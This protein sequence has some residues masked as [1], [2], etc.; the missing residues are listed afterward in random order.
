MMS[1][2][3]ELEAK[4]YPPRLVANGIERARASA[5]IKSAPISP[6]IRGQAFYDLLQAE[7]LGVEAWMAGQQ[8]FIDGQDSSNL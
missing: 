6:T 5:E 3:L 4:G 1:S 2:Q 7:M 8:R